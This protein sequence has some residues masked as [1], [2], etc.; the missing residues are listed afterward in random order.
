MGYKL[1]SP[2]RISTLADKLSC[3]WRGSDIT[4]EGVAPFSSVSNAELTFTKELNLTPSSGVALITNHYAE[5]YEINDVGII[6]SENPRLDFI[7]AL[8]LLV[9]EIGFATWNSPPVID[10]TA[11]I[12]QNVV[13]ENGCII[14]AHVVIEHNVVLHAGTRIGEYSRVR[15]CTSVG[16]DGFGF[17]RLED[18]IPL[19]F[20][21]LGGVLIGNHVEIG[22][23]SAI[24]RGTL[25]DTVIED[26]VKID[27]LVHVAHNCLIKSGAFVVACA[28]L[29]GGVEVGRNAWVAPNSCTHQKIVIGDYALVGLGAV[30]TKDVPERTVFAGNPAKK[31]RDL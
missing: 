14:G 7:K 28:E 8:D 19:R 18:D 22:S 30:V 1:N 21:H 17:E 24:A 2:V 20:P 29:S 5:S 26:N 10:P 31:I 13:I 27:N 3:H 12:G 6:I 4:I 9:R 16:G 11:V 23:C 15:S 25:S